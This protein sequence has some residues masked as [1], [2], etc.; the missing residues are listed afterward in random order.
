MTP[1]R[2]FRRIVTVLSLAALVGG[3][4]FT[5]ALW[6][7]SLLIER[8]EREF[9]QA[10]AELGCVQD[11]HEKPSVTRLRGTPATGYRWRVAIPYRSQPELT[12]EEYLRMSPREQAERL[13]SL[14]WGVVLPGTYVVGADH[15]LS[16][17][18]LLEAIVSWR[19]D[20]VK[21]VST[22][23]ISIIDCGQEDLTLSESFH[24]GFSEAMRQWWGQQW[25]VGVLVYVWPDFSFSGWYWYW[26]APAL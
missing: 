18:D 8:H 14:Y 16:K 26:L 1:E 11:R 13:A 22:S 10:Y 23:T 7:A 3:L 5:T 9:K 19:R 20:T 4:A 6:V 2:G 24:R 15:D 12:K 21:H 17:R 25:P